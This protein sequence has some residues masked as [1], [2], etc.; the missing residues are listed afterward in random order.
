MREAGSMRIAV[1]RM[2]WRRQ[3]FPELCFRGSPGRC[4]WWGDLPAGLSHLHTRPELTVSFIPSSVT[5]RLLASSGRGVKD[6]LGIR[7]SDQMART[8]PLRR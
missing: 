3:V 8:L 6:A 5:A 7:S 2:S 4:Y 1:R